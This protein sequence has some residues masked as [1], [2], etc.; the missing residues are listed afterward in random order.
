MPS[1]A[2]FVFRSIERNRMGNV[3]GKDFSLY[4][5]NNPNMIF[6]IMD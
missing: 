5:L 3:D 2:E 6:R 4:I 1:L